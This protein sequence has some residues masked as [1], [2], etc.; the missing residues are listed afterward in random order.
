M[1]N[2]PAK[3]KNSSHIKQNVQ[4]QNLSTNEIKSTKLK[5]RLQLLFKR[6][7]IKRVYDPSF[8]YRQERKEIWFNILP[9]V[10]EKLGY[11]LETFYLALAIFDFIFAKYVIQTE[12][13]KLYCLVIVSISAK[14][15]ESR[16]DVEPLADFCRQFSIYDLDLILSTERFVLNQMHFELNL[17][18]H[19]DFFC[20]FTSILEN[21][22]TFV[23]FPTTE[24]QTE[25]FNTVLNQMDFL[26]NENYD[27][28]QFS[29]FQ[30]SCFIF[31]CTR[32][33][34]G[35]TPEWPE[36]LKEITGINSS[37]F[38]GMIDEMLKMFRSI[39]RKNNIIRQKGYLVD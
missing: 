15:K 8:K 17:P 38:K 4:M 9:Q 20:C 1:D 14:I 5:R 11:S 31:F 28:N 32:K 36:D 7:S 39:Y 34:L 16:A 2:F 26:L 13:M 22:K 19:S 30:N 6:Q 27:F 33:E 23:S 24:K 18:I 10:F 29:L 35:Y 25:Q 12:M 21:S 37:V 3:S